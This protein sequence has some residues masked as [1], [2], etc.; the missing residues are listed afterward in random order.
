MNVIRSIMFVPLALIA[1]SGYAM[2]DL[3][4]VGQGSSRKKARLVA[5]NEMKGAREAACQI[6]DELKML[7]KEKRLENV[8]EDRPS[9]ISDTIEALKTHYVSKKNEEIA[10]LKRMVGAMTS[11]EIAQMQYL[12]IVHCII[13]GYTTWRLYRNASLEEFVLMVIAEIERETLNFKTG[14]CVPWV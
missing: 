11:P 5:E 4:V 13:A 9:Q 14:K 2:E 6:A 3:T 8:P 12:A 10:A 1:V 7:E